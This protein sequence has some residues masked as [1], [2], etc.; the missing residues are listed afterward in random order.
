MTAQKSTG[1]GCFSLLVIIVLF[2]GGF[3]L[4]MPPLLGGI[5]NLMS[6]PVLHQ[7]QNIMCNGSTHERIITVAR[8]E[9]VTTGGGRNSS[10]HSSPLITTKEGEQFLA[11]GNICSAT[12]V[13]QIP[14]TGILR[15]FDILG[16]SYKVKTRK[17]TMFGRSIE[18]IES[19]QKA[20]Q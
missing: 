3:I 7:S 18:N 13:S 16:I 9:M 8:A 19:A 6:A 5:L 11:I 10:V 14:V 20:A 15:K 4:I 17:V 2:F 12:D 1:C